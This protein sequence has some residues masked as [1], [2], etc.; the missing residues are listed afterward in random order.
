MSVLVL[1]I[2][3]RSA[4]IELLEAVGLD[5]LKVGAPDGLSFVQH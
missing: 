1:G 5:Q 2:S 4:P 3:H